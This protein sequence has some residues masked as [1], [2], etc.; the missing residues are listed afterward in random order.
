MRTMGLMSRPPG[1]SRR[2]GNRSI[3][4]VAA[5][6]LLAA[7]GAARPQ[8]PRFA[9]LATGVRRFHLEQDVRL[10][11]VTNGLTVA[12]A[13]D[14]NTNL[15]EVAVRY[16]VG[17]AEDPPGKDGLAHLVEH[18]LFELRDAADQPTIG[19]QLAEVALY[20]NAY[21]TADETHYTVTA[22]REQLGAVL[23]LEARRMDPRC[24]QI[25]S[26]LLEREKQVVKAENAQRGDE[27]RSLQRLLK[28]EIFG[29]AHPYARSVGGDPAG[30]TRDDVCAFLTAHYAPS[31]AILVV[32]GNFEADG[33][34]KE[35][36]RRFGP[37]AR[38]AT[39][40]RTAL[41]GYTLGGKS[42]FVAPDADD[43]MVIVALD[44]AQWGTTDSLA[45]EIVGVMLAV[46]L[47]DSD[48]DGGPIQDATYVTIGAARERVNG[49]LLRLAKQATPAQAIERLFSE[50]QALFAD[51]AKAKER[52]GFLMN[53]L[54]NLALA[55]LEPFVDR[56]TQIADHLQYNGALPLAG[57]QRLD[58]LTL[59]TLRNRAQHVFDAK[60][61][62][63]AVVTKGEGPE[64]ADV[65]DVTD[66]DVKPFHVATW[67]STV[68]P[69][70]AKRALTYEGE[71]VSTGLRE[72]TLDNGLRVIL[73][74]SL[75]YP[76][77]DARLI[78]PV[79]SSSDPAGRQGLAM[80]AADQ[81]DHG[82]DWKAPRQQVDAVVW[83]LD[84]GTLLE[85]DVGDHTTMFRA[86]GNAVFADWHLWRL[87]WLTERGV[88]DGDSLAAYRR[89]LAKYDADDFI[90]G[91]RAVLDRFLY[92]TKHPY[93]A[94]ADLEAHKQISVAD[95]EAFRDAHYR[96]KGATLVV[97][98]QFDAA[99]IEAEIRHLWGA[100]PA[101][102]PVAAVAIP[103]AK[104]AIGPRH[105]VYVDDEDVPLH[106]TIGFA[107]KSDAVQD[108][109]SR[110][111]LRQMLDGRAAAVRE[112]LGASYG[113]Y[114]S[115]V[116]GAGGGG[117][118][119]DGRLTKEL[120]GE[121]LTQLLADIAALRDGGEA[122]DTDFVL[123]RRR[124]L[125][126]VLAD[127][128]DSDSV[129][130]DLE[131]SASRDLPLDYTDRLPALVAATTIDDITALLARDL[132]AQHLIVIVS[133]PRAAA[134]A[135]FTAA[136]IADPEIVEA[137]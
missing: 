8:I 52:F 14:P 79:G 129:A 46:Q 13:P 28:Q 11:E 90:D 108:H 4:V 42:A 59:T 3:A 95:M 112:R 33:L 65:G 9:G 77:L 56:A 127:T 27:A 23:D 71:R 2:S 49:F 75:T 44:G 120:A 35:I 114:A 100:W 97:T 125:G 70:E 10:F 58:D 39:G 134:E 102:A 15:V 122:V 121:A 133:G 109:A 130:D 30:I 131:L 26:E 19:D 7:C 105:V 17:A 51:D 48:E 106:V 96:A 29:A 80:M 123:A 88:Y 6:L 86:R 62:H 116:G 37:I 50:Q 83:A 98:G 124:V 128:V 53:R 18:I 54:R 132:A 82:H 64:G 136:G 31:Q 24:E 101:A 47:D 25:D 87:H 81:L 76:M 22:L 92:G 67:R 135:A 68:D 45:D 118:I 38:T 43:T 1:G 115:Y 55:E 69:A 60:R 36:G 34:A 89:G 137:E 72:L 113:V 40:A 74:S 104:P 61:R 32:S 119:V 91:R 117:L 57:L 84:L 110:A 63:V 78:F 99:T 94:P 21:T 85:T 20:S 41:P 103:K 5:S 73:A 111:I 16:R 12:L 107:A 126:R 93:A 66:P